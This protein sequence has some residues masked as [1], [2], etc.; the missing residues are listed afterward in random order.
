MIRL[1]IQYGELGMHGKHRLPVGQLNKGPIQRA[2]LVVRVVIRAVVIKGRVVGGVWIVVGIVKVGRRCVIMQLRHSAG[3][4]ACREP[5]DGGLQFGGVKQS[6]IM[7]VAE[8]RARR[9]GGRRDKPR[10]GGGS[11]SG[12]GSGGID[13]GR[14]RDEVDGLPRVRTRLRLLAVMQGRLRKRRLLVRVMA[15]RVV[16]VVVLRLRWPD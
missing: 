6:R 12:S 3:L 10:S 11:G 1:G 5:G 9:G 15:M 16:R 8:G 14:V 2:L 13:E 4:V 7:R